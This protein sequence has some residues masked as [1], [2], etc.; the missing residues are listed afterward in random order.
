MLWYWISAQVSLP[1]AKLIKYC[2]FAQPWMQPFSGPE[3]SKMKNP[4]T[5]RLLQVFS[6]L[7]C[8]FDASSWQWGL[9]FSYSPLST[10]FDRVHLAHR[11]AEEADLP[12]HDSCSTS[13]KHCVLMTLWDLNL[14]L[15]LWHVYL[16]RLWAAGKHLSLSSIFFFSGRPHLLF[17]HSCTSERQLFPV[18]ALTSSSSNAVIFTN[19]QPLRSIE[20]AFGY[21]KLLKGTVSWHAVVSS[22]EMNWDFFTG[23]KDGTIS[24]T[25]ICLHGAGRIGAKHR[26]CVDPL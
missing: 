23:L 20:R 18:L 19:A 4:I 25:C 26:V 16:H 3:K 22:W 9:H 13:D 17:V 5:L 12:I 7:E 10:C 1:A 11:H 21:C 2:Q 6:T 15:D 14:K 8:T 24:C